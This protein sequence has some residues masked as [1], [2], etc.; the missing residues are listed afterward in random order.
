MTELNS[1]LSEIVERVFTSCRVA[2]TLRSGKCL[3]LNLMNFSKFCSFVFCCRRLSILLMLAYMGTAIV[4][5][6]DIVFL[7]K[8]K[9]KSLYR[10]N[11]HLCKYKLL[12][13]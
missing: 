8:H 5:L 4:V 3:A 2:V 12:R 9:Q 6:L 1:V 7:I 10:V 11:I 13:E